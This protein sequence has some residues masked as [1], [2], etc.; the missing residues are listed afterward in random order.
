MMQKP[1]NWDSTQPKYAG[2]FPKLPAGVYDCYITLAQ[3]QKS[4]SGMQKLVLWLDIASGEYANFFA[5]SQYKPMYHQSTEGDSTPFFVG[6]IS[7]IEK[8]NEGYIWD[9]EPSSLI[10]KRCAAVFSDEEYIDKN[11]QLR[12]STKPSAIRSLADMRENKLHVPNIKKLNNYNSQQNQ[13]QT[14]APAS[15]EQP[16]DMFQDISLD[17]DLPF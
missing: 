13:Q 7:D 10:N 15:F 17:D 1:A 3:E 11:G 6:L 14:H 5:N 4:Q 2:E 16:P 8:S 12:I 9:W